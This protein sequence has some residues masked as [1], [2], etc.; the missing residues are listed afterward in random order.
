[1][2]AP[3]SD[4]PEIANYGA[5]R[6]LLFL[7]SAGS[8]HA[9]RPKQYGPLPLLILEIRAHR[10]QNVGRKSAPSIWN[11]AADITTNTDGFANCTG[12]AQRSQLSRVALVADKGIGNSRCT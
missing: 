11:T 5:P 9:E 4:R 1:M 6:N 8:V 12:T 2:T 3:V 7:A 10:P